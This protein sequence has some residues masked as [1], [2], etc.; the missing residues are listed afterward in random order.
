MSLDYP[1]YRQMLSRDP[2]AV[3]LWRIG[4]ILYY[5]GLLVLLLCSTIGTYYSVATPGGSRWV[6]FILVVAAAVWF[7]GAGLKSYAHKAFRN[8][9][10]SGP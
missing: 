9:Q 10:A 1:V 6:V 3:L 8:R 2:R 5:V 4:D 7:V